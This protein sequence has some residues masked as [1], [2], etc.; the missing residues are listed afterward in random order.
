[1]KYLQF[2]YIIFIVFNLFTLSAQRDIATYKKDSILVDDLLSKIKEYETKNTASL[3]EDARRALEIS[4]RISTIGQQ[5]ILYRILGNT[6]I[7]RGSKEDLAKATLHFEKALALSSKKGDQDQIIL[8]TNNLS[9]AHFFQGNFSKALKYNIQVIEAARKMK[10]DTVKMHKTLGSSYNMSGMIYYKIFMFDSSMV[11]YKRSASHY[12]IVNSPRYYNALNNLGILHKDQENHEESFVYFK[13]TLEG[14][15]KYDFR[16]T[17]TAANL[18]LGDLSII[19]ENYLEALKYYKNALKLSTKYGYDKRQLLSYEGLTKAYYLLKQKDSASLYL[20]RAF[21][22]CDSLKLVDVK[23]RL[24]FIKANRLQE[25]GDYKEASNYFK[26]HKELKDS[27]NKNNTI[28]KT[29][30][31]L[32][33]NQQKVSKKKVDGGCKLNSV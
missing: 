18:N 9:G 12:E 16:P 17:Q 20:D 24:L 3:L 7:K 25:A 15:K 27:L 30:G 11:N 6:L 14:T 31:V 29:T 32:I 19:L 22:L 8:M 33:D 4:E 21:L 28:A 10:K 13:K 1:M 26:L 23:E 5:Y 2:L